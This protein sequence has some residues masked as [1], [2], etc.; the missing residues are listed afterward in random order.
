MI[1]AVTKNAITSEVYRIFSMNKKQWKADKIVFLMIHNFIYFTENTFPKYVVLFQILRKLGNFRHFGGFTSLFFLFFLSTWLDW[2]PSWVFQKIRTNSY[3][4]WIKR[5]I[6]LNIWTIK[7][8]RNDEKFANKY[9]MAM[10]NNAITSE[11]YRIFLWKADKI[12]FLLINTSIYLLYT[13]FLNLPRDY[14]TLVK[15]FVLKNNKIIWDQTD[16]KKLCA[17]RKF[18]YLIWETSRETEKH[19]YQILVTQNDS[20]ILKRISKM[21]I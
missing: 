9:Y 3:I 19:S 7:K 1:Y 2:A 12:I 4:F 18:Q 20:A 15:K 14:I 11:V 8:A 5:Y 10:S 17:F 21:I 6:W 16:G 13:F